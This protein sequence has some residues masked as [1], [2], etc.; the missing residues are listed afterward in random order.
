MKDSWD[1]EGQRIGREAHK[2]D[3]SIW[4]HSLFRVSLELDL[5]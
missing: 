4:C 1:L 5:L 3:H 2:R